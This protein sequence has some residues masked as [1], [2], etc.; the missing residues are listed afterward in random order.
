MPTLIE[1]LGLAAGMLTTF[2]FLPQVIKIWRTRDVS[3]ISLMMYS[4]FCLGVFL[5]LLFGIGIGSISM[6]LTNSVTF[7]FAASILYLKIT[8]E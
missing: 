8:M 1:S 3:A 5:W 6:I 2:S 4:A 7:L